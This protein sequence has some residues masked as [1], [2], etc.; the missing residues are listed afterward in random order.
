MDEKQLKE[1]LD[2]LLFEYN[3]KFGPWPRNARMKTE[4]WVATLET[5]LRNNRPY[6]EPNGEDPGMFM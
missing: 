5:C 3:E 6:R 2:Q 4:E 1:R